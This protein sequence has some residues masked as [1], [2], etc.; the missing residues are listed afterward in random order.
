[1]PA[2]TLL[3]ID[4]DIVDR[5]AVTR[6][7]RA[8]GSACVVH[9]ASDGRQGLELA[10]AQPVDCILVDYRLPDLDGLELLVLLRERPEIE[11]PII[12]LTGEGNELVAVEAMK[13][14]AHDYLP[15]A[16]LSPDSLYRVVANAIEK[17]GLQRQLGH[18]Q[19]QLERLALYDVLTDLGNRNLFTRELARAIAFADRKGTTFCLLA[20]DLDR[21]KVANDTYGHDAGDAVLAAIGKRLLAES[22]RAD[23][24]FRLGGDEFAALV[25]TGHDPASAQM[26][27]R[28][29]VTGLTEPVAWGEHQLTVGVSIG[30]ARYPADGADADALIRAADLAMYDAKRSGAGWVM[31]AG[32]QDSPP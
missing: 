29:L 13:R 30:L 20:M 10:L 11:A 3:I 2:R 16:Q 31:A 5:Q 7:L 21:F 19:R 26:L 25:E 1:M 22:R 18:A 6:A 27:A 32:G 15:K 17:H 9:E 12:M 14:G 4:D 23:A 8:L 28:R 24:V